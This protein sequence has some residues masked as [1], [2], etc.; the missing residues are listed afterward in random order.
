MGKIY[1]RSLAYSTLRHWVDHVVMTC[2][3]SVTIEGEGNVPADGAV[4][5]A[6][7]HCNTLMD[8]LVVLQARPEPVVFGARSDIF[9][10]P[11]IARILRFLHIV[12]IPRV[13]NGLREVAHNREIM[14]EV[15]EALENGTKYCLFCEGTHRTK[16]SLLPVRKGIIRTALLA[17]ERFGERKTIWI[18]PMGIEYGDYFRFRTS[19][20]IAY[21]APID[22]T[23][24][25]ASHADINES[26]LYRL[27]TEKLRT[28]IS[29]LFTCLPDDEEYEGRWCI[30]KIAG[31]EAARNA[32]Q[33][34]L[35]LA[36]EFERQ[37]I[38]ERISIRSMGHKSHITN[39]LLKILGWIAVLPVTLFCAIVAAPMWITSIF[40]CRN[41][42]DPAFKNTAR[43]GVKFAMLP[44]MVVAWA[45]LAFAFLPFKFAFPAFIFALFSHSIFYETIEFTRILI[46]DIRL[47][48]GHKKL[49][50]T[51][52]ALK[53]KVSNI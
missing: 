47:C 51:Y 50:E 37:R 5:F 3:S 15:A 20:H 24:F 25:V 52:A 4:I 10:K 40:V 49:K 33:E 28:G 14:D 34:V 38:H 8:A 22:I 39:T 29:S 6:P 11:F 44:L 43:F 7:N 17:N 26:E 41:I 19:V 35:A 27:L 48:F 18:V 53:S 13:R 42:K 45:V 30:T 2:F 16:H 1:D 36:G 32:S 46:S 31:E 23:G 9:R 21:G 12:P